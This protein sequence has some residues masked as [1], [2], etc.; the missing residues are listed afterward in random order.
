MYC[1]WRQGL[2]SLCVFLATALLHNS[3]A[4]AEEAPPDGIVVIAANDVE[5]SAEDFANLN[6]DDLLNTRLVFSASK[7]VQKIGASPSAISVITAEDIRKSGAVHLLDVFRHIP[8][9][10]VYYRE[11]TEPQLS[12]RGYTRSI[13]RGF[14]LLVDGVS[15]Y[16]PT[17][18]GI[19]WRDVP[20]TIEDIERIEV[21]RGP[22]GALYGSN[23][24]SG[25][26]NI[27]TKPPARDAAFRSVTTGGTQST[28]HQYLSASYGDEQLSARFSG[29]FIYNRGFGN[30]TDGDPVTDTTRAGH[31]LFRIGG[32]ATEKV[33]FDFSAA[34]RVGDVD[35]PLDQGATA[36]DDRE[37]LNYYLVATAN[38]RHSESTEFQLKTFFRRDRDDEPTPNIATG[39]SSFR[40]EVSVYD[41]EAQASH[42]FSSSIN[43]LFGGHYR[44][45]RAY[46]GQL[47]F[48][49]FDLTNGFDPASPN[50]FTYTG[51]PVN[52]QHI[53]ASYA[54]VALTPAEWFSLNT[55]LRYE[56]DS[57]T[58]RPNP[59]L[60]IAAVFSPAEN[61]HLRLAAGRGIRIPTQIENSNSIMNFP[62][63][64]G[65]IATYVGNRSLKPETLTSFE[66]GYRGSFWEEKA[67]FN[68]ETFVSILEDGVDLDGKLLST[69]PYTIF[70][71]TGPLE[72]RTSDNVEKFTTGGV[73]A[74]AK[75]SPLEWLTLSGNYTW[76]R[77]F[78][79]E[80]NLGFKNTTPEHMFNLGIDTSFKNG[81]SLG[82]AAAFHSDFWGVDDLVS[83]S[84]R[85]R[86]G[87]RLDLTASQ[88]FWDKKIRL[89]VIGQ[90]VTDSQRIDFPTTATLTGFTGFLNN[91]R[92][93]RSFYGQL[94]I[95][96]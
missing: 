70:P 12:I 14:L 76:I 60:N 17:F 19:R 28:I 54:R 69:S 71:F 44:F 64:S 9:V 6:L 72:V 13:P 57:F 45:N 92:V 42:T 56:F 2:R 21:I 30:N 51:R 59:S 47:S 36:P 77:E 49:G 11:G 26:I 46:A 35:I 25:V 79:K 18:G 63:P 75:V 89:S 68:A 16:S 53:A 91:T 48:L 20:V 34:G 81:T 83:I 93:P 85:V 50:N 22:G 41:I 24:F 3:S 39:E 4:A 8:G 38:Y 52:W 90:N 78:S 31:Y 86:K 84:Q 23:G 33:T 61:Q 32:K 87:F 43:V 65:G 66:A 74:E 80:S 58:E 37:T 62:T 7:K 82:A 29:K 55:A 73:E 5:A 27:V 94:E 40:N 67:S 95:R 10:Y 96:I 15:L 1:N 88:E